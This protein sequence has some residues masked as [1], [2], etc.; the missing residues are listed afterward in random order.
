MCRNNITQYNGEGATSGPNYQIESATSAGMQAYCNVVETDGSST[1]M[2]A[3]A[4]NAANRGDNTLQPLLGEQIVSTGN[5]VHHN[6]VIWDSGSTATAG[7]SQD[8]TAN[9]PNFF[10]NNTPPNFNQY[11]APAT[12]QLDFIYDNNNS[13]SNTAETFANYQAAGGDVNG[14]LDTIY[15]SGFP[16][17]TITS[18]ADQS[19]VT[20]PVTIAA[21]AADASGISKVQFYVDWTLQATVTSGPYNYSWA[22]SAGTHTIAAM[23]FSNA[24]VQSCNAVTLISPPG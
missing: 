7:Y 16:T 8:D 12:T 15:A 17:V 22:A 3:W 18:P 6:T 4:V 1:H 21:A 11:H 14:T 5:Y 2:Q 23:A 20:N 10:A 13:G 19:P 9:Q 24:G